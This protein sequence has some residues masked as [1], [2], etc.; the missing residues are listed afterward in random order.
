MKI[1]DLLAP[2]L[3]SQRASAPSL[4]LYRLEG[5]RLLLGRALWIAVMLLVGIYIFL[6]VP[7]DLARLEQVCIG[8]GC[9]APQL[10]PADVLEL[11][12][13]GFSVAVFGWAV[14]AVKLLFALVSVLVGGII[15]WRR[16]E[17]AMALITALT[18]VVFAAGA[19]PPPSG[20]AL[21]A[22]WPT[23]VWLFPLVAVLASS[24][25]ILI[26]YV[27]PDGRFVPAWTRWIAA[28]LV[29]LVVGFYIFPSSPLAMWLRSYGIVLT[30]IC[31]VAAVYAQVYRYRIVSSPAERTQTKWVVYGSVVAATGYLGMQVLFPLL[32]GVSVPLLLAGY[33]LNYGSLLLLPM[34]IGIA[35]LR[36]HLWDIDIIIN[37]TLVY[38]AL[39]VCVVGLYVVLVGILGWLVQSRATPIV[40]LLATGVVAVLFQ[41]LRERVER[42]VNRLLYGR[43]DEPYVV[44]SQLGKRLEAALEPAEALPTIVD[45]VT[46]AFRLPYAAIL[47]VE[48][49]QQ[50]T[51]AS[52]GAPAGDLLELPLVYQGETLGALVVSPRGERETW[53]QADLRLLTDLA[54]QAGM[55]AHSVRLTADLCRT[56]DDLRRSRERLVLAREEERRRLRRD[57]H[58][59]VGSA[60]AGLNFR[61]G[62]I[63]G[64]LAGNQELE[65]LLLEQRNDIRAAIAD[66][67]RLVYDLR[68]PALDELG[69][70]AALRARAAQAGSAL[71]TSPES[72]E[73]LQVTVESP[74]QVPPLPAAVEVAVYRIAQEALTN[75]ARHAHART[76]V[77]SLRVDTAVELEVVDDGC[78]IKLGPGTSAGVGLFS[79][80]ERA[81]ELGGVCVIEPVPPT[82]T[83]VLA[84]IPLAEE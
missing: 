15:F 20:A 69:L 5:S 24:P 79:M 12:S 52:R 14:V 8:A 19:F 65:A 50:V 59:G 47:L 63:R 46:Q 2:P 64:R 21:A 74:E 77:V 30:V 18:L 39:T 81:E 4:A 76:C 16:A 3:T 78:G 37:R 84:W 33:A 31:L 22:Q 82:G 41:S 9:R 49:E 32:G 53:S 68:P 26:L 55:A 34:T 56:T 23:L 11:R 80:R 28:L 42:W 45:T 58:D 62:A 13:L 54:H 70:V 61:V 36:A 27:F 83:R 6:T 48:G 73:A 67:R 44:L 75:V 10:V 43:R 17:N 51:A 40:S 7:F 71:T 38:G 66:I 57:L 72:P 35:V 25:G 1:A 60:L 29:I